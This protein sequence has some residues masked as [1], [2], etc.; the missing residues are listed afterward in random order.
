M[1]MMALPMIRL[2]V[3]MGLMP[4]HLLRAIKRL[5]VSG[6][7]ASGSTYVVHSFLVTRARLLHSSAE[8]F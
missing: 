6:A 5:A 1:A 7:S 8:W 2:T 3:S 4:G